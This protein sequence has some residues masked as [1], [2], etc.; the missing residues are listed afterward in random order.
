VVYLITFVLNTNSSWLPAWEF[1]IQL[2]LIAPLCPTH[3]MLPKAEHGSP[4]LH[5]DYAS[6]ALLN[7]L[8]PVKIAGHLDIRKDRLRLSQYLRLAIATRDVSKT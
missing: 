7:H 8:E 1:P 5:V 2:G 6:S 4:I 3:Q